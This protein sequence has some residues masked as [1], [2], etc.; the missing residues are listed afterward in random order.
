MTGIAAGAFGAV[1]GERLVL[2]SSLTFIEEGAFTSVSAERLYLFDGL[3]SVRDASFGALNVGTLYV[4]ALRDPVYCGTYFDTLSQKIDY[5][6]SVAEERKLILFCGSSARFGYDSAALEAAFPSYRVVDM[7]VYAYANMLPQAL[8]L[9]PYL[10][11]GDVILSSPE[12]DAIEEQFCATD[13][14][15]RETWCMLESN[16]DMLTLLDC[17]ALS[18]V[19]DAFGAYQAARLS[20]PARGYDEVPSMFDEDR[21]PCDTPS[22][23]KYGDYVL[24]RPDNVD[25]R[26]FGVKR[27]AFDPDAISEAC[28]AG[29]DRVFGA[30]AER[31]AEVLF[32][33]SPRSRRSVTA[34]STPEAIAALGAEARERLRAR[35]IS[36]PEDALMEA[37]WF[38]GTDNHLSTNGAALHTQK[39]IEDLTPWLEVTP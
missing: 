3:V 11:E 17:R 8:L 26:L 13:R 4:N 35:V 12:L 2:P 19:F 16:Y 6:A 24:H 18:G 33:W 39:V 31:G 27:A 15:D 38:Y 7:G 10:R 29:L 32:T 25:G 1:G 28:W 20:L 14:M 21:V 34:G 22:Y 5:L 36:D 9:L 23:N 30:F 37:L